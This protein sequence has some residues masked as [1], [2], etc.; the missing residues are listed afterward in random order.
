MEQS[1]PMRYQQLSTLSPT[2]AVYSNLNNPWEAGT[3]EGMRF[4]KTGSHVHSPYVGD[5]QVEQVSELLSFPSHQ[6]LYQH[7]R[8]T[9]NTTFNSRNRYIPY[10]NNR[11]HA[12][13][14]T[15]FPMAINPLISS[16]TQIQEQQGAAS[17]QKIVP[18]YHTSHYAQQQTTWSAVAPILDNLITES[19]TCSMAGNSTHN[20][21]INTI[22]PNVLVPCFRPTT[23]EVAIP[24]PTGKDGGDNEG[25]TFAKI[26][27]MSDA[28][29]LQVTNLDYSLDESHLRSFLL[30]QLKPITPVVSLLFEGSSYAKITVPD[31]YFAKQVVSNLH[32]KKIGHKRML[33]SYTRDSS[34]T[35]VNTLRCQ[36][37]G[38]LKDVP[39]NTLPM[40][41]FRELFQSR[42]KTS[43]SVLDLYK[44][45]DICT[46]NSDNNEEK[47][48]RL[49]PELV[50]TLDISPLMEGLQHS[51]PYCSIHFKKEQ[52]KG[53]AEQEIE[54]LQNVFMS[55]SEIQK[56]IYP[57]LKVHTGDIPVATLLHCIKEV[58]NVSIMANENGVNLEH[59]ICCVQGI[60]V[61]ANNFG[62]KIVGW[63]EINKEM[64]SG[65]LNASSNACNLTASDRTNCGSYFK[66]SVADPLFQISREVIEL[67]KMSPKSTMK[68][69]RFIPAYHNHFG[70]QCRVADYGYTKLIELFEALSNVVQ[71]MGDGENRQITLTHRIQIRRFTSDLLRVLRANGNNSVLLSQL[72]LVF[73]QTQ[74][75]TFDIT[76]YGVCDL[77]DILDGLVSSNIVTLGT[78]QNGKDILISMPKRKQTNS[79]LEKT[80]VFAGEMVELFQNALQYTILFQKFVRSYHYH[81]AY[82]CRL[83]DYG[84]LKLADLLDAINGLVDMELTSDEDKKIVL[85]PKVARRVFAEQCENLIRNATGNSSYCMKLDQVLTLHKKKYGYQIQPKTLGVS[86]MAMA[87]ELLPYVELKKKE[88][89]IW[90]ICHNNDLEFRFLCYRVCK[91]VIE[92]DPSASALTNVR[93]EIKLTQSQQFVKAIHKSTLVRDFNAKHKDQLSESALLAMRHAI[94]IYNDGGIQCIRLTRFM[95]FLIAIVRML[96]Q[97]PSMYLYEIK[98]G[99]SCGLSTTFEFGFPNLYSVIAAHKDLFRINNGPTQERSEVS[100]NTKC[101]LRQSSL[102][103]DLYMLESQ[104]LPYYKHRAQQ[105]IHSH[106]G[107]YNRVPISQ[108]PLKRSATINNCSTF[109]TYHA[110][111][112]GILNLLEKRFPSRTNSTLPNSFGSALESAS[113]SNSYCNKENSMNSL[114]LFNSSFNSSS[115]LNASLGAGDL[116]NISAG[117]AIPADTSYDQPSELW[118]RRQKNLNHRNSSNLPEADNGADTPYFMGNC[119]GPPIE[120]IYEPLKYDAQ[121][122]EKLPFWIDPIW[123]KGSAQLRNDILNIRLPKAKTTKTFSNILSPYTISKNENLKRQLFNFDNHDRKIA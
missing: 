53:W 110:A 96:E 123:S 101:E 70:K 30:N 18:L 80:C 65:S 40:Y 4:N 91:Y 92:R 68:F 20:I 90:L 78:V 64:Q 118:R 119:I 111:D 88:Q 81:F 57:L 67:L 114:Q 17:Y 8:T 7:V 84:F 55:I 82:Q 10:Y 107:E 47:F 44:M 59:L 1:E 43:I 50:N 98:N 29:T 100:I 89:A 22:P 83:S 6:N 35:E 23:T 48:I 106:F 121:A 28:V 99:L 51:V 105:S 116:T 73:T 49:N 66:N 11:P 61:R 36:V 41:K 33:V 117:A 31:L 97:R 85:S 46:I 104:K 113:F 71:I 21:K 15:V 86:D 108:P 37:A 69:N 24:R 52:H 60:Q 54:P 19:N 13:S 62:I 93:G 26:T 74:N 32:R 3:A 42:F 77:I 27:E 34:L 12:A 9:G 102:S 25:H 94:E 56:L 45:Q 72:P 109:Q 58:L 95:R 120:S 63:I 39:F 76:D 75:K 115:E 14:A 122:Q 112:S 103:K 87:V 5:G 79:E 16:H 38:L 2:T